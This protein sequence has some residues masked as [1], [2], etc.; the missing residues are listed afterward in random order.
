L[1]RGI[2]IARV[3]VMVLMSAYDAAAPSFDRHRVLPDG[4]AEAIRAAVLASIGNVPTP[5]LLDLG[6]GTGRIGWPFVAAGDDYVGVDL[7][8]GML[9]AFMG[10]AAHTG[11]SPRLVQADG[12]HLPFPDA[13][14]D[15][16]ML[17]QLFGG[18]RGW[19]RLVT[20]ARRVVR[21]A[22]AL[23]LGRTLAPADGVDAQMKQRLALFLGEMGVEPDVGNARDQVQHWLESAA[24]GAQVMIAASWNAERTPRGF[25]LRHR[26][27]AR[28]AALPEPIKEEALGKLG[29]WA[30]ATF[31]SVDAVFSERHQF[32]LRIFKFREGVGC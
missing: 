10:R 16:V 7:S 8:L 19:R 27:G 18:L 15:A 30:A 9:Q 29:A 13:T 25:L 4:V 23:A 24:C 32:E 20:E 6:A 26:T 5:R 17:V 11:A 31:G 1:Y 3:S 2:Q 22:G 14:F 28:F 12:R 21:M